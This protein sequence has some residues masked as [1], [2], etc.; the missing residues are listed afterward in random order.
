MA[1]KRPRL[2]F[3]SVCNERVRSKKK[4]Q[5]AEKPP[6]ES[7]MEMRTVNVG[8]QFSFKVRQLQTCACG[9]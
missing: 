8:E 2:V 5:N 6:E 7:T 9:T 4:G 1:A 3:Q